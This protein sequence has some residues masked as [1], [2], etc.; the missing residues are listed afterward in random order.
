MGIEGIARLVA[1]GRERLLQLHEVETLLKS[2]TII[3]D[4]CH[5][6]V[7]DG[8]VVVSLAT[9]PLLFTLVRLLGEAW[10][11]DVSRGTLIAQAFRTRFADDS[12][13]ARLRVEVGRLRTA[14][15][16]LA[17]VRATRRGFTLV[18]HGAPEVVVLARPIEEKHAALLALLIVVTNAMGELPHGGWYVAMTVGLAALLLVGAGLVLGIVHLAGRIAGRTAR[19]PAT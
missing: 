18:L 13:R 17:D 6:V 8:N 9:R 2:A 3:V 1:H 12:H 10:P 5:H 4:A 7:R 16:A 15:G 11:G 19:R 14:L